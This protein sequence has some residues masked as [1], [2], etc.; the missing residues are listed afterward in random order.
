[1]FTQSLYPGGPLES[2]R[3]RNT[4]AV[5][6][7]LTELLK[8]REEPVYLVPSSNG[9][10]LHV[11]IVGDPERLEVGDRAYFYDDWRDRQLAIHAAI[12]LPDFPRCTVK[13]HEHGLT[14][15]RTVVQG[16]TGK[17]AYE[18]ECPSG[19]YRFLFIETVWAEHGKMARYSRP[20]YGWRN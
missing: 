9:E 11:N 15:N 3:Y 8:R 6:R 4:R 12:R 20:R 1:M 17:K 14:Y 18:L 19:R 13:G 5:V 2:V 10:Y 7:W 16:P